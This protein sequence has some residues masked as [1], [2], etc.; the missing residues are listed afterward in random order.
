MPYR[1]TK[2][3]NSPDCWPNCKFQPA[4]L[5][6]V[7]LW[8]IARPERP[9]P[10]CLHRA[11]SHLGGW[12]EKICEDII[13]TNFYKDKITC[14]NVRATAIHLYFQ[15]RN[16]LTSNNY[17]V[18]Q[19]SEIFYLPS[20]QR[21][22]KRVTVPSYIT[23]S[24]VSP[25]WWQGMSFLELTCTTLVAMLGLSMNWSAYTQWTRTRRNVCLAKQ[26]EWQPKPLTDMLTMPCSTCW[27]D[28]KPKS[29]QITALKVQ[30]KSEKHKYLWQHNMFLSGHYSFKIAHS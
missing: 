30:F 28:Y 6:R 2:G 1:H 22:P 4:A 27:C 10:K 23:P 20:S 25:K 21:T 18:V 9:S 5:H 17:L 11:T 16:S 3:A 13:D 26:S 8:A 24:A 14:M 29:L 7:K 19:I 12:R 15:L